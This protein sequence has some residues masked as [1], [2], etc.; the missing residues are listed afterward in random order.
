VS[1]AAGQVLVEPFRPVKAVYFLLQGLASMSRE[2][3]D[4]RSAGVAAVGPIGMV[5]EFLAVRYGSRSTETKVQIRRLRA[6]ARRGYPADP[7][8]R[9]SG[10]QARVGARRRARTPG[11]GHDHRSLQRAPYLD[12]RLARLLLSAPRLGRVARSGGPSGVLAMMLGVRRTGV[13]RS[14]GAD[15]RRRDFETG[16]IE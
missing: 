12:Q 7:H 4:G 13:F 15:G 5:G 16:R 2:L 9:Q 11:H 1:L 3:E 14:P 6:A 10:P 8:G